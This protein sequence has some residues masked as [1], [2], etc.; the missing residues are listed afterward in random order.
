MGAAD[1][2]VTSRPARHAGSPGRPVVKTTV[3]IVGAGPAGLLIANL[4]LQ[5]G[6]DCVVVDKFTR[7]QVYARARAGFVE[8]RNR[9]LLEE[10]G[11]AERM[12]REG[13]AHGH[14]EFRAFGHSFIVDYAAL[15]G[16][17]VHWVYPQHELVDDM[18]AAFVGAGGDLRGGMSCIAVLDHEQ[19]V[20]VCR[21][22]AGAELELRCRLLA[23]CDGFHGPVRASL[24]AGALEA[25][26]TDHPFQWIAFLVEAPPSSDHVVY[27]LHEDGY[28]AHM[29]RSSTLCRYYLQ[30]PIGDT[31]EDWPDE[32]VWPAL[33]TRLASDGFELVEGPISER[34]PVQ[35]RSVVFE[36]MQYRNTF[37]VGDAAH[38]ITPSGGKGMNIALRDAL[39]FV[40][41][42]ERSL[43]G[44]RAALDEYSARRLPDVWRLQEF[45]HWFLHMVQRYEP[46]PDSA[47]M[48]R[49]QRAR[50]RALEHSPELA[51]YFAAAY[52]G[53]ESEA[54]GLAAPR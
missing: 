17:R 25:F 3:G 45:S 7:E 22:E 29:Q 1:D 30:C 12:L 34:T 36:P 10:V 33:G 43:G 52:V 28:A 6:I 21:D 40:E 50:L 35:L 37:L 54:D 23:G 38:I 26:P 5:R 53:V 51:R 16:G 15:T 49:L 11:L 2:V 46:G 48:Q 31:A 9:L 14:C 8:W 20:V 13:I 41:L 4:L 32:R 18:A 44:E 47:F 24:P 19:P 27:A 39:A 42:A